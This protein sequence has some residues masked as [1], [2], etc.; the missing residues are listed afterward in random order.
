MK[1]KLINLP[2]HTTS[3]RQDSHFKPRL[4]DSMFNTAIIATHA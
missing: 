1:L 2:E 3:E 4:Y